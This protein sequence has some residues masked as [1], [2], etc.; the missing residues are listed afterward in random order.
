M[1]KK[2]IFATKNSH[3]LLEARCIFGKN[4]QIFS[5]QEIVCLED[6]IENSTSLKGNALLKAQHVYQTYK[7]DCFSDDTGLEVY[8]LNNAP[9]IYSS[10]YA[11]EIKNPKANVCKLLKELKGKNNRSAQF[12]TVI[13]LI[14]KGETIFFEGVVKGTIAKEEKGITGFDYDCIFIPK[15][16][17][18]TFAELGLKIKNT[19][20]HRAE[21]LKKLKNFLDKK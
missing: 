15:G 8:S 6:I 7:L 19:I 17:T 12:R 21:A 5:L 16:Y 20:S 9:G 2:L 18:K 1:I 4:F 10:R 3:K 11:G 13:A 14:Y